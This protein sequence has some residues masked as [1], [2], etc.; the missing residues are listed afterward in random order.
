MPDHLTILLSTLASTTAFG[1]IILKMKVNQAAVA[2]ALFAM[3][4]GGLPVVLGAKTQG[5]EET[6]VSGWR[7]SNIHPT[8]A[9]GNLL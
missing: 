8:S 7:D 6:A 2:S 1:W 3:A 4:A 5:T 9:L